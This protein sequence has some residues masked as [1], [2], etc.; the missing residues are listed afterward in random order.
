MKAN[1]KEGVARTSLTSTIEPLI[2]PGDTVIGPKH[3]K[4]ISNEMMRDYQG[5]VIALA[6]KGPK[7]VLAV[8][9][10]YAAL[11]ALVKKLEISEYLV[12]PVP[13]MGVSYSH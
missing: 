11:I 8:A 10:G 4:L 7:K 5:K 12:V 6:A 1:A 2:K 9:D 13:R 3:Q